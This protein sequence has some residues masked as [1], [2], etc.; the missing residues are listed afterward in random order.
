MDICERFLSYVG[1][2]TTSDED[3]QTTPSTK[4]QLALAAHLAR[5]LSDMGLEDTRVDT[6]GYVYGTLPANTEGMATVGLIAHMDTASEM[7]AAN[8]KARP[9]LYEGGDVLLAG[10]GVILAEELDPYFGHHLIVT[11]GTTLLGGDDKAGIAEIM[12]A[13]EILI[14]E[15][16]PHGRVLV[17]FTPDEEIGRGADHFDLDAF[18]AD[19]AYTMDGGRLGE[20]EYENFN[21]A[22]ATVSVE[23]APFH[24]G[25]AKGRMKNA[26][27]ILS[28]LPAL[29]P[30]GELPELTEGREGFFHLVSLTGSVASADGVWLIRDH[31]D[32]KFAEKK[33]IMRSAVAALN[34]RY[35]EGTV[36]LNI[37]D[38]YYNMRRVIDKAPHTVER[39]RAAMRALGITPIEHPIRGGTDGALLSHRG[40]PCPNLG[41]GC[42]NAHSGL[43]FISV[44]DMRRA[45]YLIVRILEEAVAVPEP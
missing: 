32:E 42:E 24:P 9:F 41:T 20:L 4:G 22:R 45:A 40:L 27:R 19:Y 39:A 31:D 3:S 23:G 38:T 26:V 29:L 16:P 8:V 44:D 15:N 12:T 37:S 18:T 25:S 11:D 2:E 34:A 28:E 35:G 7:P 33:E 30:Q 43:E 6:D 14:T 10:G 13:L 1:Y 36:R 5:E 21:A 17:C